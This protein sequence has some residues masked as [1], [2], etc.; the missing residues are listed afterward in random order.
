MKYTLALIFLGI[1]TASGVGFG[2]RRLIL[3]YEYKKKID[4]EKIVFDYCIQN[5]KNSDA[6][7][8]CYLRMKN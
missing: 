1:V 3:E 4:K 7:Q 5:A 6:M 8:A 2:I